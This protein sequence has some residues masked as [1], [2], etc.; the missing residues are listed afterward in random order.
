MPQSGA[1]GTLAGCSVPLPHLALIASITPITRS[2]AADCSAA[3]RSGVYS[4]RRRRSSSST[5][6][7]LKAKP[8]RQTSASPSVAARMISRV[9]SVGYGSSQTTPL[10]NFGSAGLNMPVRMLTRTFLHSEPWARSF[11]QARAV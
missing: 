3:N 11:S 5:S 4:P 10:A 9:S 1:V 8:S 6:A 2:A 7:L